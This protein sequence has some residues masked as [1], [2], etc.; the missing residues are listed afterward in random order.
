[1]KKDAKPMSTSGSFVVLTRRIV[2]GFSTP[3]CAV[4]GPFLAQAERLDSTKGRVMLKRLGPLVALALLVF[5]TEARASLFVNPSFE[6]GDF[7]GWITS[8][9]TNSLPLS[10]FNSYPDPFIVSPSWIPTDGEFAA[11]SGFDGESPGVISI[12]QDIVLP[13]GSTTLLFDYRAAWNLFLASQDRL[14]NV[15]VQPSGG[16]SDLLTQTIL[17]VQA[18]TAND[19]FY[20]TG[21]VDLSAYGGQ[22]IRVL[23][24]LLV[25]E[26]FTGPAQFELD[27]L[28]V[29]AVPEPAT[30]LLLGCGLAVAGARR[31]RKRRTQP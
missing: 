26:S 7:T 20:Q 1:M 5:A 9:L 22:S 17:T 30:L 6:T 8:D 11:F 2:Q 15:V 27:N 4:A 31:L 18:Q 10:V 29:E 12:A 3:A 19:T 13:S 25:P 23:F 14:F 24:E 28:R 16:G 21:S